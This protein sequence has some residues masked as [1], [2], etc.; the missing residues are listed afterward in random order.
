MYKRQY[1]LGHGTGGDTRAQDSSLYNYTKP[2]FFGLMAIHGSKMR[3]KKSSCLK[4]ER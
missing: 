3:M 4:G 2:G 1:I